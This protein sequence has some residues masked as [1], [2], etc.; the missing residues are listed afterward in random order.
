MSTKPPPIPVENFVRMLAWSMR[1]LQ[2][3]DLA[4][5]GEE[6]FDH[7]ADLLGYLLAHHVD[8]AVR[9]GLYRSYQ[10]V[11]DMIL[12]LRGTLDPWQTTSR[13]GQLSGKTVCRWDELDTNHP[14]HR[15]IAYHADLLLGTNHLQPHTRM[16][17]EEGVEA[18]KCARGT[19]HEGELLFRQRLPHHL[20]E[21][22]HIVRI[23]RLIQQ[24]SIPSEETGALE[25]LDLREQKKWMHIIFEG[26]L[27]KWFRVSLRR[28]GWKV[29][30]RR[31]RWSE[32]NGQSPRLPALITD[33]VL[34]HE[35]TQRAWVIDAKYYINPLASSKQGAS[36]VRSSHINQMYAYMQSAQH[37]HPSWKVG[38]MLMYA[39]PANGA[40]GVTHSV[41]DFPLHA[42]TL[43][44]DQP[45]Q[46][47]L[48]DLQEL[49]ERMVNAPVDA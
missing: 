40:F 46:D 13:L 2:S 39:E 19:H 8:R 10:P 34:E 38:G 15:G 32:P 17:L 45:W 7:T 9:Q 16:K 25:V 43:N 37:Q 42:V 48:E 35:A 21:Y 49:A 4:M 30:Q 26:F 3:E 28:S 47:V 31:Y 14:I 12:G 6:S 41:H 22:Q 36:M 29:R 11:E 24:S 20:P 23:C 27:Y 44:L 1:D 33:I 5:L 18:L